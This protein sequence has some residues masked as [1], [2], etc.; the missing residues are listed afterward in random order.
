LP[1]MTNPMDA[2]VSLQGALDAR[3]VQ[4]R[5]CEIHSDLR[6]L[7][8]HP[9]THDLR[10]TYARV[11]AGIVQSIALFVSAEP[12]GRIPCMALGCAVIESMRGRGLGTE[13]VVKAMDE[14]WNGLK[15]KGVREFYVEGVV[16]TSNV[17]SNRLARRLLSD[18]PRTGIE[19]ISGEPA[20]I[21][22]RLLK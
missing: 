22:L 18:S 7:L 12:V 17:A 1:E 14:L 20:L 9:T 3:T 2:L 13:T 21:Y 10:L 4:M 19:A 16:A 5:A 6:V 8:D 11:V 15:R